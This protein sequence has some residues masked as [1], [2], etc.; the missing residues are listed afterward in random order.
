MSQTLRSSIARRV[1]QG[2]YIP[3]SFRREGGYREDVLVVRA[4]NDR[5]QHGTP[6]PMF[7]LASS[8]GALLTAKGL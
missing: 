1:L 3:Q 4:L 5:K 6:L 7:P 2:A 8:L